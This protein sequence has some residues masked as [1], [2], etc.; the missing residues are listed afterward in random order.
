MATLRQYF[1]T[2]FDNAIRVHVTFAHRGES[3]EGVVL[4]DVSA[5]IAYLSCYLPGKERDYDY[6]VDF[7]KVLQYGRTTLEL[8][9]RIT[10]PSTRQFHGGL[11]LLKKKDD[12]EVRYRLFGDP[13]WRS[14]GEITMSRRVFIYSETNL[15]G[16]AVKLLQQAADSLGHK[17]QFRS[18]EYVFRRTRFEV[19]LAFVSYDS[20]DREAVARPIAMNL[21]KMLC[22]VWYDEFSLKVGDNLRESIQRGLKEC[23]KCVLVLSPHF[24][25]NTGWTK[26]EFDSVFTREILEE[27]RLVLPVWYGVTRQQVFEYSPDLLN[28]KGLDWDLLGEEEVCR[29][30]CRAITDVDKAGG[31]GA[32]GG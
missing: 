31:T 14:T 13:E 20:R 11:E 21:Q 25:S 15:N 28:V 19:V 9:G 26:K 18:A 23:R 1:E 7:L 5:F 30:L 10:L 32:L 22:P 8:T 29:L 12:L 16:A 6:F 3:V 4:Y 2:D 17:L 27:T 24:L